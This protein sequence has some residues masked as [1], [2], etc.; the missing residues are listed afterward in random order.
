MKITPLRLLAAT[1]LGTLAARGEEGPFQVEV[2][3]GVDRHG[4]T[5]R[6]HDPAYAQT[7]AQR[8]RRFF[9]AHVSEEK[10]G[11][12]LVKPVDAIAIAKEVSRP[13]EAHGF[14]AIQG[15]EKPDIVITVK[16]GRG[17]L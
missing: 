10:S 8:G 4:G 14:H 16:Y 9:L 2:R 15:T 3:S 6:V 11:I 7:I 1:L 13:L 5:E 12:N 17:Y